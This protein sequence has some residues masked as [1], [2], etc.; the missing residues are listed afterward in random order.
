MAAVGAQFPDSFLTSVDRLVLS[1]HPK[2]K[3][4]KKKSKPKKGAE[5]AT[6]ILDEEKQR[7]A[8]LFPGL[9]MP[10][11]DWAPSTSYRADEDKG[12]TVAGV[13]DLMAELEG[14]NKRAALAP[15]EEE[16]RGAKRSR[17]DRS[18]SPERRRGRSPDYGRRDNGYGRR[19]E[20]R[21]RDGYGG[22]GRGGDGRVGPRRLDDKPVMYKVYPGKVS[23][24]KDF[25]A[26]ISLEGVAGRAEGKQLV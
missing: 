8:R 4:K 16:D 1:M 17:D 2:Y 23:S 22:G 13:D 7:Q 24:M 15:I 3:K 26:F 19:D 5:G 18:R 21:G 25:G 20:E 6:E 11:Q 14:V 10:D 9:A 12:K